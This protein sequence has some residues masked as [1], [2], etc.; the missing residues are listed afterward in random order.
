M[1]FKNYTKNN[2][3][4]SNQKTS[5]RDT[6]EWIKIKCNKVIN[7]LQQHQQQQQTK[8]VNSEGSFSTD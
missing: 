2:N 3:K 5:G 7:L 1:N 6:N 4:D 8:P